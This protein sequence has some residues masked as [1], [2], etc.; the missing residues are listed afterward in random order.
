MQYLALALFLLLAP[1]SGGMRSR[2]FFGL[3]HQ[4][5]SGRMQFQRTQGNHSATPISTVRK[6]TSCV[7][8]EDRSTLQFRRWGGPSEFSSYELQ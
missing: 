1:L 4:S 6:M 5:C 2:I 7:L 3:R 8:R